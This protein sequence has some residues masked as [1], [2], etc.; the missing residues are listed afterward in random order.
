MRAGGFGFDDGNNDWNNCNGL[1]ADF[2]GHDP[3]AFSFSEQVRADTSPLVIS[4][5]THAVP[6]IVM[7]RRT[8]VMT[9]I[10]PAPVSRITPLTHPE[11]SCLPE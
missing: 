3:L 6:I 10:P 8:P 2:D 11:T 5:A 9:L 7:M 4:A 1:C